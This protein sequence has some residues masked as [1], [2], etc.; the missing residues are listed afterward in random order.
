LR[1]N[2]FASIGPLKLTNEKRIAKIVKRRTITEISD[3]AWEFLSSEEQDN[4]NHRVI[5][6][7]RAKDAYDKSMSLLGPIAVGLYGFFDTFIL[8]GL[9]EYISI[10]TIAISL[11]IFAFAIIWAFIRISSRFHAYQRYMDAQNDLKLLNG[12]AVIQAKINTKKEQING[13]S[14]KGPVIAGVF[15]VIWCIL[16]I[17]LIVGIP[18]ILLSIWSANFQMNKKRRLQNEIKELE[19]ELS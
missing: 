6:L 19:A 12:H 5:E 8:L 9:W 11:S 2:L 14:W 13:I 3:K 10:F 18:L 4:Y 17:G 7:D 15:G 1:G 16:V